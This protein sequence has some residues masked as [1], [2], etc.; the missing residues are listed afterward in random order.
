LLA[1]I[2]LTSAIFSGQFEHTYRFYSIATDNVGHQESAPAIADTTT[3]TVSPMFVTGFTPTPSGFVIGFNRPLD[4]STLNLYGTETG[5]FGPAD[6]TLIGNTQ[7]PNG[8][9]AL[10]NGSLVVDSTT[11]EVSFVHTGGI[12]LP[13]TYNL[14]LRSAA[15]GFKDSVVGDLLDGNHDFTSGDNY[16]TSFTVAASSAVL[17]IP[18]FSRGAGQPVDLAGT[19][20]PITLNNTPSGV[21]SV[22]FTV[23]YNPALL[24]LSA[25]TAGAGLPPGSQVQSNLSTPGQAQITIM[26]SAPL[27]VGADELV[28]LTA[29]VPTTAGYRASEILDIT[30]ITINNGAIAA[31]GDNGL[32]IAAYIGDATGTGTYSALDGQRV[33]R[34]AAGLDSGFALFNKIDP[35]VIADI[36][37]NGVISALDATRILQEVVGL[38]RPEI[39]PLPVIVTST[40]TADQLVNSSVTISAGGGG[41][42]LGAIRGSDFDDVNADTVWDANEPGL[43]RWRIFLDINSNGLLDSFEP[44]TLTGTDGSY[45]FKGLLPGTYNVAEVMQPGWR[46]TFPLAENGAMSI[47]SNSSLQFLT[48]TSSEQSLALPVEILDETLITASTSI[49]GLAESDIKLDG[50]RADPRF[51]GIDGHGIA[52]VVIDT[53]ADLDHPFFGPDADGNGI[54]DRIIYQHD[55]ADADNDAS[56]R[57]GHG[58]VISS[59]IGSEDATYSGVAPGVDLI[60]LKVFGDNGQGSFGNL[61]QALQWSVANA[62]AYHIGVVNLSLGDGGNWSE[63]VSRYG[64]GDELAALAAE[65]VLVVAAAGNNFYQFGSAQGLAYPAADP[66]VFAVG[67]VWSGDFGGPWHFSSG[68]IDFTTGVDRIASFSQRDATRTDIFAP[69]ARVTGA[70]PDGGT[71]TMQGTSQ[72]AAYLSGTAVLAQQLALQ[73]LG[74]R[75]TATEFA[76]LLKQSSDLIVDGDDENDNV[77]NTGFAFRRVDMLALAESILSLGSSTGD[78]GTP[79]IAAPATHSVTLGAGQ[80]STGIN[81]GNHRLMPPVAADDAFTVDEDHSVVIDVLGNDRDDGIVDPTTVRMIAEP[82]YGTASIESTTGKILYAPAQDFFGTDSFRYSVK[83]NEGLISNE[84]TVSIVVNAVND[85]PVADA[86]VDQNVRLGSLVKLDGSKSSDEESDDLHYTWQQTGGPSVMLTN[87]NSSA[88]SFTSVAAGN[89]TFSLVVDDGK[90]E[91]VA[92]NVMIKVLRLGD[93]DANGT[94]D[95]MDLTRLLAAL[96]SR[97]ANPNDPYD[98]DGDGWITLNDVRRFLREFTGRWVS[99]LGRV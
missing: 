12:L 49:D 86:G 25:V 3:I 85:A 34:V 73:Y 16:T 52:A 21:T 45:A 50:F 20:I 84:A 54:A 95:A 23:K 5:G 22:D 63:A 99:R 70:G 82:A 97:A 60:V 81:F 91:S 37:G 9:P 35:V 88:P 33:L 40:S 15:N 96:H 68:A 48:T 46:Q 44:S 1:G 55:F 92:D 41:L 65:N 32:H 13:D 4:A 28:R 6:L 26:A 58:S 61:E 62:V 43:A 83:D 69:G 11:N 24:T 78:N 56:D 59:I 94:I 67:A 8:T 80:V 79:L 10:I 90:A 64:I 74:R 47:A 76:T 39:P 17:S 14:T 27:G 72:A 18:D 93:V 42:S 36:T 2:T 38:D 89:Y 66:S 51:S 30:N 77:T 75:L 71:L 98:L 29:Q 57:A 87:G 31:I 7:G 53:G 19:G